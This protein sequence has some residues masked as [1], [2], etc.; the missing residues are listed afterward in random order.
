MIKNIFVCLLLGFTASAAFAQT[1]VCTFGLGPIVYFKGS[2]NTNG[3]GNLVLTSEDGQPVT[4]LAIKSV[5]VQA[6]QNTQGR[7]E[8]ARFQIL[9]NQDLPDAQALV[10]YQQL[11]QDNGQTPASLNLGAN[12]VSS[13]LTGTCSAS[14]K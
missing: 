6:T 11:P 8:V 5:A 3:T 2:F 4:Q 1:E 12:A 10:M 9:P 14:G 7:K 13:E